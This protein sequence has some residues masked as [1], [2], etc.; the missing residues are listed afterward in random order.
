MRALGLVI[1]LVVLEPARLRGSDWLRATV[2]VAG[3]P[4]VTNTA[5]RVACHATADGALVTVPASDEW[6]DGALALGRTGRFTVLDTETDGTA[7]KMEMYLRE[8]PHLWNSERNTEPVDAAT[9]ALRASGLTVA[10]RGQARILQDRLDA[11]KA[12]AAQAR[13]GGSA[14]ATARRAVRA[15]RRPD[16]PA[17]PVQR[18]RRARAAGGGVGCRRHH[19]AIAARSAHDGV[20][21]GAGRAA[22][23]R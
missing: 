1:D 15:D 17:H 19:V 9:P 23:P 21:R 16:D 18:R 8:L 2:T 22:R 10:R 13:S 14:P 4:T 11:Q 6:I 20:H 3:A 5:P 12:L 7:L